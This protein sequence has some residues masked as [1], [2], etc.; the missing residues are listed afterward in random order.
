[1]P[2]GRTGAS[3]FTGSNLDCY[4]RDLGITT[5]YLMRFA[6]NVCVESTMRD[7]HDRGYHT[8][9]LGDATATFTRSQQQNFLKDSIHHFAYKMQVAD[10]TKQLASHAS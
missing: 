10:F 2:T 3:A 9:V 6:S 5:L 1:M 7:A 8:I 4:L